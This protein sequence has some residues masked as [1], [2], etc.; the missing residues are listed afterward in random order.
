MLH[1][2][3]RSSEFSVSGAHMHD[4]T[5]EVEQQLRELVG[6]FLIHLVP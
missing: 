2:I 3:V 4:P 6:V 1:E 5:D